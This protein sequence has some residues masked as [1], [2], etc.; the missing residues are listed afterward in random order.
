MSPC[1]LIVATCSKD[2]ISTAWGGKTFQK[3][4]FE[5]GGDVKR[6]VFIA[7]QPADRGAC[8]PRRRSAPCPTTTAAAA[9]AVAKHVAFD[10]VAVASQEVVA[11]VMPRTA[12]A[13]VRA[14]QETD[15]VLEHR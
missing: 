12:V 7:M 5:P 1:L 6:V 3:K 8:G 4:K 15:R 10:A 13:E 9:A 11:V 2:G 14:G